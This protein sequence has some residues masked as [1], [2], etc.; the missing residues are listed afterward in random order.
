MVNDMNEKSFTEVIKEEPILTIKLK[1]S[2]K[3]YIRA[4]ELEYSKVY[5]NPIAKILFAIL[6]FLSFSMT[7][8][9]LS[10]FIGGPMQDISTGISYLPECIIS[11]CPWLL[12]LYCIK[13]KRNPFTFILF[14]ELSRL[15]NFYK[16]RSFKEIRIMEIPC[17]L[18]FY[19]THLIKTNPIIDVVRVTTAERILY[20][21]LADASN[22][23]DYIALCDLNENK[24]YISF[25]REVF[26]PKCQIKIENKENLKIIMKKIYFLQYGHL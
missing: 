20:L 6:L 18:S 13:Q 19:D 16:N 7:I 24:A 23:I 2:Y 10:F 12:L 17:S 25:C 21:P 4:K 1:Y 11:N 22:Q 3:D 5:K 26:I 8:I 9:T 15:S 14:F